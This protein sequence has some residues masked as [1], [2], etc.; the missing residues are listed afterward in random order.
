MALRGR[1]LN[2]RRAAKKVGGCELARGSRR[3]LEG[4]APE[5]CS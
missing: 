5:D 2:L 3:R 1:D 4:A